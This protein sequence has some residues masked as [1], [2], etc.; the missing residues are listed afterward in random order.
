MAVHFFFVN[1]FWFCQVWLP[2]VKAKGLEISGTFSRRQG[3][4]YMDMTF[5]NKALQHMTDFAVQFNKNRSV[6]REWALLRYWLWSLISSV[7]VFHQFRDDS[8]QPSAHSHSIDAQPEYWG[9]LASQH[10]W[11]CHEDGPTEQPAGT[12]ALS[13]AIQ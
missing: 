2:A 6:I 9:L 5:T 4:M 7:L 12:G 8:H 10:Y 1:T 3:H 13:Q 11:S